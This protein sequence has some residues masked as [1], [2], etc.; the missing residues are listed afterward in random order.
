MLAGLLAFDQR[1]Q[2]RESAAAA[3]EAALQDSEIRRMIGDAVIRAQSDPELALLLATE[4]SARAVGDAELEATS[5]GGLQRVLTSTGPFLGFVTSDPEFTHA[6]FDSTGRSSR[7][8]PENS[9]NSAPTAIVE[10]DGRGS[11]RLDHRGEPVHTVVAGGRM[12]VSFDGGW[13]EVW[14]LASGDLLSSIHAVPERSF[15]E[16]NE[17]LPA[18][19]RDR[20]LSRT[21]S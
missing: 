2:A 6:A 11:L 18:E 17:R 20:E 7:P 16:I 15:A 8:S 21:S 14:D 13:V 1:S 10:R 4:A 3:A 5:L 19:A 12:A 9:G